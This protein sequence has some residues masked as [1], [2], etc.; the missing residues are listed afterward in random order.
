MHV[1]VCMP[2]F[3]LSCARSISAHSILLLAYNRHRL[4]MLLHAHEASQCAH[5]EIKL[6]GTLMYACRGECSK[7]PRVSKMPTPLKRYCTL[8]ICILVV[9]L[10]VAAS[11]EPSGAAFSP[12]IYFVFVAL[13]YNITIQLRINNIYNNN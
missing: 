3:P 11:W 7:M 12:F 5:G 6:E 10:H 8:Q 2:M 13:T 4:R 9:S 1:H